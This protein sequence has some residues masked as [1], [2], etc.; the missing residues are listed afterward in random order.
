MVEGLGDLG[1][2]W[3]VRSFGIAVSVPELP[4]I[5][6]IARNCRNCPELPEL[7][8]LWGG[9]EEFRNRGERPGIGELG[10]YRFWE[11]LR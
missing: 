2:G 10:P 4:G 5:A 3:V 1:C 7:P 8:W 6:G 11:W 9:S